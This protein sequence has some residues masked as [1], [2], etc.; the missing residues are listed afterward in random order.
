MFTTWTILKTVRYT[1]IVYIQLTYT[2]GKG[3]QQNDCF[4][5]G[6]VD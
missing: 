2:T 4:Y 3:K 5:E 1:R 6:I